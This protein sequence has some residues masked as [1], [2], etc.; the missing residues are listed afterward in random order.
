MTNFTTSDLFLAAY[1]Y[2][3]GETIKELL[4]KGSF[5]EI[6]FDGDNTKTLSDS[7]YNNGV[8]EG[9]RFAEAYRSIK[10]RVLRMKSETSN[11]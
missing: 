8:V 9:R 10:R 1:L 2:T 3:K 6:V 11:L 5:I 7:Y 4:Q